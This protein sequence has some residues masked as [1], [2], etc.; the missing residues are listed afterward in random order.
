MDHVY[1]KDCFTCDH[2][3][4]PLSTSKFFFEGDSVYCM[5]DYESLYAVRCAACDE[6]ITGTVLHVLDR[7][8]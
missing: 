1:H 8:W 7:E 2:C 5:R 6:F 3:H 4:K